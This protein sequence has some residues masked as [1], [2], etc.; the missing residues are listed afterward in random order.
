LT[1][2]PEARLRRLREFPALRNILQETRLSASDLVYPLFV[3]HG[4]KKRIEINSMPGVLQFSLDNLEVEIAEI[5]EL[6]IGAVLLFGLPESKDTVGSASYKK[7]GIVQEAIRHIK[8]ISPELLVITDV[9]LCGYTDHGHCG[10]LRDDKVHNDSTLEVLQTI[11]VSH[12]EAGADIVAPSAMMDGQVFAI[13][14]ALDTYDFSGVAIMSYSAKYSSAFYGPFRDAADSAPK[15]GDRFGYQIDP[16]NVR[17]A[18]QEV[19]FDIKE[20][21]DIVMVKPA[22]PYLDMIVRIRQSSNVPVAAYNV[23]GEYSMVKAAEGN[24]WIDYTRVVLEIITA[25][26]RAG[27]DI[28]ISYHSKDVARSLSINC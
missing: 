26:K 8:D 5:K 14:S 19:V 23:S 15:F 27:A 2:F 25:I 12:A 4:R 28:I 1:K 17:Q 9:C 21:A 20:S 3:T 24:G 11:A 16:S 13:R 6:G 10:L 18:L 7:Q 22:L